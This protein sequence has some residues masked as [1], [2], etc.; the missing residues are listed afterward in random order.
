MGEER[1]DALP[2]V[3]I[4]PAR[5]DL[6]QGLAVLSLAVLSLEV[7]TAGAPVEDLG[8]VPSPEEQVVGKEPPLNEN[9]NFK[10]PFPEAWS[11]PDCG[12]LDHGRNGAC[13]G[14]DSENFALPI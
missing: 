6:L 14:G 3:A 12:L 1:G 7:P 5:A 11:D 8:A 4:K 10:L 13:F 9:E 2:A